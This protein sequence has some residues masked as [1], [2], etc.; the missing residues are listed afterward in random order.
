MELLDS[1]LIEEEFSTPSD[2][3]LIVFSWLDLNTDQLKPCNQEIT[4]WDIDKLLKDE[5]Q[6]EL[7]YLYWKKESENR[8]II[9]NLSTINELEDEA[10]WLETMLTETLNLYVKPLCI[11]AYLKQWWNDSVK[12]ARFK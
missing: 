12:E 7:A 1:W 11:T 6:L 2:H 4:G 10:V 9:D 8:L 5:K 3:E